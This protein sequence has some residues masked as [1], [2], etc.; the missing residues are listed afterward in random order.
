[1]FSRVASICWSTVMA[2]Y[3]SI[4]AVNTLSLCTCAFHQWQLVEINFGFFWRRSVLQNS[5]M[6][7]IS[8]FMLHQCLC[9]WWKE[10]LMMVI[11]WLDHKIQA[12]IGCLW[13]VVENLPSGACESGC[14]I[15]SI[16][17]CSLWI[18]VCQSSALVDLFPLMSVEV[19][20]ILKSRKRIGIAWHL[21]KL[22]RAMKVKLIDRK[23]VV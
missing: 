16:P 17:S 2:L 3:S 21:A 5:P 22:Q 10:L 18:C 8:S 14:F 7:Q 11:G 6:R 23:S 15:K 19:I 9:S 4:D 12:V 1:M 13:I 20:V